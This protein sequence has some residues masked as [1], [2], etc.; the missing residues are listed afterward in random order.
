MGT[1][2][3][4]EQAAIRGLVGLPEVLTRLVTTNFRILPSIITE[5]LARDAERTRQQG[6]SEKGA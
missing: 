1:V 3:V 5:V 4:L 2:G 6:A